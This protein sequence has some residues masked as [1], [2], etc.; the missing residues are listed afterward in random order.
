MP[1]SPKGHYQIGMEAHDLAQCPS[2]GRRTREGI[3][4]TGQTHRRLQLGVDI[5]M[6]IGR[7]DKSGYLEAF[8]SGMRWESIPKE[9]QGKCSSDYRRFRKELREGGYSVE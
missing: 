3:Y 8:L 2:A 6:L 9:L 7:N 1:R 5:R 4:V